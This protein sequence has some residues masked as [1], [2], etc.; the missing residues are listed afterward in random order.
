MR[1]EQLIFQKTNLKSDQ[2]NYRLVSFFYSHLLH[3]MYIYFDEYNYPCYDGQ[4]SYFFSLSY[5]ASKQKITHV[6]L[7]RSHFDT[8][9]TSLS[10]IDVKSTIPLNLSHPYL[11]VSFKLDGLNYLG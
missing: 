5:L 7:P 2:L 6:I 4:N 8:I 9:S 1:F 3:C 10:S 11:S